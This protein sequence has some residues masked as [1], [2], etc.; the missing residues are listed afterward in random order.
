MERPPAGRSGRHG[1]T[2]RPALH[3][4]QSPHLVFSAAELQEKEVLGR[5]RENRRRNYR[6]HAA[7]RENPL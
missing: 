6:G 1:Q 4:A 5:H 3:G 2:S 7:R